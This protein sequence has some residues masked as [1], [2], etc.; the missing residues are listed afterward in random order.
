ME[1]GQRIN[2]RYEVKRLLGSGGMAEVFLAY[3]LILDRQVAVKMLAYN[4]KNDRESLR[5]F[6][7]EAT[8]TTELMHP[9]IVNIYDVGEAHVPYIVME[10]IGGTD[11][12][13]YI[14]RHHPIAHQTVVSIMD[15]IL[16]AISYAHSQGVIHRDIKPYNILIDE[17]GTVKITD[18][19]IA[20]ALS[21][22]S[23][24]QTNSLL[25]SVHY[26][27]PEQ[28]RGAIATKASDIYSLGILLYE[29]LT[30]TV[31][32][33]GESAV[34]IA[35]KHF[36]NDFPS[37]RDQQPSIPQA[38]EN[39]ILK[40]TAKDPNHRYSS[41][42]AMR[43]DLQTVLDPARRYE[44]KF[45]PPNIN[46]DQTKRLTPIAPVV[47]DDN[48]AEEAVKTYNPTSSATTDMP[49]APATSKK[50]SKW[51]VWLLFL[52]IIPVALVYFVM[53]SAPGE[54]DV[55]N[56]MGYTVAQVQAELD[57]L[58]LEVGE[59]IN[60]PNDE[61]AAGQVIKSDPASGASVKEGQA[62][63][64]FVS[65]GQEP[66]TLEDYTNKDFN[67]MKAQLTELGFR[68]EREDVYHDTIEH[69]KIV[70]QDIE[71][72]REVVPGE[73]TITFEVSLGPEGFPFKNLAGYSR[74]GVEDY[75]GEHQLNATIE[76]AYSSQVPE[77]QVIS[78]RPEPG[79]LLY[80][81]SD[82]AVVFSIGPEPVKT[83]TFERTIKI[84]YVPTADESQEDDD[85]DERSQRR[86]NKVRVY[87]S[88]A[89]HNMEEP[90][91]SFDSMEDTELTLK[92]TVEKGKRAKY[93]VV[94]D[95]N[96]V[97]EQSVSNH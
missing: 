6:T 80:K 49:E 64:L 96:I 91:H 60:Q 56:L 65:S 19:G 62:I 20:L 77:G 38:L 8:S 32:F 41:V 47:A 2:G 7:R 86:P 68:V 21:Q 69:E 28:A 44:E 54:V 26:I 5:R 87:I 84:D 72:G 46:A 37:V 79:T 75:I 25:G 67:Q 22:N 27:S 85:D 95:G 81:Q 58:N 90:V 89:D 50:K 52:L 1:T 76:E 66:I 92:F 3:D 29:L 53:M 97:A 83:E 55:P 12:K 61:I 40:A 94:V 42:E 63:N 88:D 39:V 10:Y 9:N 16:S 34:S 31:P 73:T 13:E 93:R 24:T 57:T 71:A 59:V 51:W 48:S 36:Q 17:K 15:K 78:Q 43:E 14:N 35:L 18:F 70:S 4:F 23:L 82:V 74:T 11:L 30:G 45:L 33:K